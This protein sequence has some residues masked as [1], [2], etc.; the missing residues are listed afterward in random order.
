MLLEQLK[1]DQNVIQNAFNNRS[2]NTTTKS[3]SKRDS[4]DLLGLQNQILKDQ[5]EQLESIE[6]G[7]SN[8][9]QYSVAMRDE[10]DLHVVSFYIFN[11]TY[12]SIRNYWMKLIRMYTLLMSAWNP[13]PSEQQTFP[14]L[15]ETLNS[16][17][18]S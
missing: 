15:R 5:D 10:S 16:I 4:K 1:H 18:L 3:T 7:V 14:L 6:K 11:I 17:W 9:H 8:L 13:K 12:F 2:S